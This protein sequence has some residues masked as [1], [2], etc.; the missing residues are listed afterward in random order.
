MHTT[1]STS[2]KRL[3]LFTIVVIY[4]VILAGGIVRSTGSGMGCPDWPKCFGT[5][6]PPTDISQL[7]LDYKEKFKVGHHVI[8]DFNPV[9]TWVE[10]VNRLL[11]VIVGFLVFATFISSLRYWRQYKSWVWLAFGIF[12]LTGIQGY[13]GAKVVA[14]NL[15]RHMITIH[16]LI[17]L[18]IVSLALWLY[19]LCTKSDL[20]K[21]EGGNWMFYLSLLT[22]VQVLIGTQVRQEMDVIAIQYQDLNR[23]LWIANL[24]EKFTIHR[25][26]AMVVV[27]LNVIYAYYVISKVGLVNRLSRALIVISSLLVIEYLSGLSMVKM[28][29][30]YFVQPIHLVLATLVFGL[31]FYVWLVISSSK[32]ENKIQVTVSR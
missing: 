15:S 2:F 21:I 11:G 26:I 18:V 25:I 17:A 27:L 1:A 14:T 29:I 5:W 13:I 16:M 4:L 8:A 12:V 31:Q 3:V 10:Y 30:P 23:D 28:A 7:P 19:Y 22:L 24:S 32:K 9:K 20:E 6:V